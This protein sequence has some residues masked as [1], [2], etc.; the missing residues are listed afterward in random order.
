MKIFFNVLIFLLL[1][2]NVVAQSTKMD[3]LKR[4]F[5]MKLLN[6]QADDWNK[7]DIRAFMEGYWKSDSLKF[8]GK[9]GVTKG[10]QATFDNYKKRYPTKEAM[11][12]LT[13]DIQSI[14]I[15]DINLAFVVGKWDLARDGEMKSVGGYFSLVMR[16]ILGN[17]VI[18]SDHTS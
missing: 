17:W 10:W 6:K 11:G 18:I 7:G 14:D 8:I 5:I 3:A 1:G 12:K 4:D 9:N 16:R 2:S 15:L 13:F